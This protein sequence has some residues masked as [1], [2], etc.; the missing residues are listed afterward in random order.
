MTLRDLKNIIA[1]R[2]EIAQICKDMKRHYAAGDY[3]GDYGLN[4][5][6]GRPVPYTISGL[7]VKDSP[8]LEKLKE[9]CNR[10]IA[11]F[12][13]WLGKWNSN[14]QTQKHPLPA[15]VTRQTRQ[16]FGQGGVMNNKK[17]MV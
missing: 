11:K 12:N 14:P 15:R 4:C 9:K 17:A 1:L 8:A 16:L 3:V 7:A 13:L 10:R 5:R 2:G 6:S